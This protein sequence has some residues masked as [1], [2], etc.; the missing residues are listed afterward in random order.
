MVTVRPLVL[1]QTDVVG[2]FSHSKK[3]WGQFP[4]LCVWLETVT[5]I[6]E[7]NTGDANELGFIYLVK[8]SVPGIIMSANSV[9]L[10][11][12]KEGII[13]TEKETQVQRI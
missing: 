1:G 6:P 10:Q 7:P 8:R 9:P 13:I 3:G 2:G 4:L 11:P 5:F 12:Y